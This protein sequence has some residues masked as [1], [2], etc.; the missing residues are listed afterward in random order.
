MKSEVE[1]YRDMYEEFDAILTYAMRLI[2]AQACFTPR[3]DREFYA[4]RIFGKL[5]CHALTLKRLSPSPTP[6]QAI[7]L[8]DISSNYAIA[9]TLIETYEALAYIALD[10]VPPAEREF[11]VLLWQVHAAERRLEML[12]LIGSK[13]IEIPNVE[14]ELAENRQKLL[15][16]PFFAT[17]GKSLASKVQRGDAPPFH[18]SRAERDVASKI[19][20]DYHLA[21]IMHLSSHVHTHPFSVYQLFSFQA[22]D[23]ECLRLM[24]IPVQYSCAFLAKATTGMRSLFRPRIPEAPQG[25]EQAVAVWENLLA[26]GVKSAD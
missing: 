2:E 16:H 8:W 6:Q 3:D 25:L 9:R 20:H 22:G 5:I 19:D 4:E 26:Q 24:S 11:R 18:N 10:E 23:S 21:V 13:N 17:V 1:R 14:S 12:R 7:E 15:D